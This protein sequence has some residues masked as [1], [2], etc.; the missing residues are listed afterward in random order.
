[1]VKLQ[2]ILLIFVLISFFSCKKTK[3]N[4]CF[5]SYGNLSER[6]VALDSVAEFRLYKNITYHIYQDTLKKVIIH[7]GEKV[8]PQINVTNNQSILSITNNNKC[9][10]LRD[11]DKKITVEIHYP[12][13]QKIYAEADDSVLFENTITSPYLYIQLMQGGGRVQLDVNTEYLTMISD[14]G[15]GS[16]EV[17]GKTI[18]ADLRVQANG[19]GDARNL[20]GKHF[21]LRNNS[22]GDL[23]V[24]LDSALVDVTIK[25]TGHV[26]YT[27]IPDSINLIRTGVGELIQE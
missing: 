5:K 3:D 20:T 14:Q 18:V 10:F 11:Y 7:G 8:I 24:D 2:F 12:F 4:S 26:I 19:W 13:Y 16:Y 21:I 6:E 27:G 15:V 23:V 25:G 17:S 1:M 22:T 9:N